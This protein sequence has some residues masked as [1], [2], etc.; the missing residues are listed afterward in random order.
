MP[1]PA[2]ARFARPGGTSRAHPPQRTPSYVSRQ[3]PALSD[4]QVKKPTSLSQGVTT[5]SVRGEHLPQASGGS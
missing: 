2:D 3:L 5:A 4:P 1:R